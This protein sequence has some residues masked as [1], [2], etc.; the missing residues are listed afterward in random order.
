MVSRF[1]EVMYTINNSWADKT[2]GYEARG[3]SNAVI[4]MLAK[5]I[6]MEYKRQ[7]LYHSASFCKWDR[8]HNPSI[9]H[10]AS[11]NLYQFPWIQF[12]CGT[13]NLDTEEVTC[14]PSHSLQ[15]NRF[16]HFDVG[17]YDHAEAVSV[18]KAKAETLIR[19]AYDASPPESIGTFWLTLSTST[20]WAEIK[21]R[22]VEWPFFALRCLGCVTEMNHWTSGDVQSSIIGK[23][24]LEVVTSVP[25]SFTLNQ[26]RKSVV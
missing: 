26:D 17:E 15:D 25:S 5:D 3:I 21:R 14:C 18:L 12:C 24:L 9:R 10:F 7:P 23:C 11:N 8:D 22:F 16:R 20:Q 6:T 2:E 13:V 1:K 19:E 4:G